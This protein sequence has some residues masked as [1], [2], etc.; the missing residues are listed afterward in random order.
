MK[1]R[2]YP[3]PLVGGSGIRLAEVT[4]PDLG[5]AVF[6]GYEIG[7]VCIRSE[8]LGWIALGWTIDRAREPFWGGKQEG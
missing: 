1:P 6:L 8:G 2:A 3:P 5:P 7:Q 4:E